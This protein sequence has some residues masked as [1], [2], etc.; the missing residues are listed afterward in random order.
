M[1]K[2]TAGLAWEDGSAGVRER[3][4]AWSLSQGWRS[5]DDWAQRTAVSLLAF[6][7]SQASVK[8]ATT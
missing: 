5:G 6:S 2:K 1:N 4:W 7:L 8:W 3:H